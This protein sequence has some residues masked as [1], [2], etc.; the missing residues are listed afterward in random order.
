MEVTTES[1]VPEDDASLWRQ[2]QAGHYQAL[3]LLYQRYGK[4]MLT[5][6]CRL[7]PDEDLVK[8]CIQDFFVELWNR[9]TFLATEVGSVKLY[10]LGGLKH[11]ILK[12][13][14]RQER[15]EPWDTDNES[16]TP[17]LSYES[18]LVEFENETQQLNRLRQA[19][20]RLAPRQQEVIHL[21][22]FQNL[23]HAETAE[24]MN[25]QAQSVR[26]LLHVALSRLRE[27]LE[28]YIQVLLI[29]IAAFS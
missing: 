15:L 2:L 27:H 24:L 14:K 7:T 23:S 26:N 5:Y 9:R 12:G 1:P 28:Y 4:A 6:G 20:A 10:L 16:E 13:T 3:G 18:L 17:V 19:I 21:R 29:S 8:D 11:K 25:M 22:F